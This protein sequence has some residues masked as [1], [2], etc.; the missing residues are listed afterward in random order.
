MKKKPIELHP[1]LNRSEIAK[2]FRTLWLGKP[3]KLVGKSAVTGHLTNPA[4]KR[5]VTMRIN[6][7]LKIADVI[8]IGATGDTLSRMD[9]EDYRGNWEFVS[10]VY[11]TKSLERAKEY[12]VELI[13][14]FKKSYPSQVKNISEAKAG[15]LT[16]YNGFYY[17]YVVFNIDE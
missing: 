4:T 3:P 2:F 13:K 16:T 14:K 6:E 17:I 5:K 7:I 10:R 8:K 12:E 11:K 15:R 9:K 1:V